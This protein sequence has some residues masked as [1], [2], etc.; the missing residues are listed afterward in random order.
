MRFKKKKKEIIVNAFSDQLQLEESD[1]K[2]Q[3][4]QNS[5]FLI[6]RKDYSEDSNQDSLQRH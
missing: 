4:Y 2:L 6:S 3:T 5:V 1:E